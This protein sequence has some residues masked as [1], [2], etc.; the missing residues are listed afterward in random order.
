MERLKQLQEQMRQQ[1][2]QDNNL[3]DDRTGGNTSEED[4][5]LEG[6]RKALAEARMEGQR[7]A[8]GAMSAVENSAAETG[9][10]ARQQIEQK[11]G[12]VSINENAV[13][14]IAEEAEPEEVV[15]TQKETLTPSLPMNPRISLLKPL[16]M[17]MSRRLMEAVCA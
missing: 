5:T 8:S 13:T 1:Q 14:E 9:G 4:E 7:Q 11:V 6:L 15:K 12:E 3:A 10:K 17:R 2:A 16:S